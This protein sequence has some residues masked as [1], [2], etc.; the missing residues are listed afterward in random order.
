MTRAAFSAQAW[1]RSTRRIRGNVGAMVG[2]ALLLVVLGMAV[3]ADII[4]PY[5]STAQDLGHALQPP[6][7]AHWFGTDTVGRDIFSRV[8]AGSRISL[9]IV[10]LVLGVALTIGGALGSLAGYYGGL[11][12]EIVMR[13]ADVF[14]AFP[15][16]LLAMAVVAAL[17][18]G[19]QNAMIAIAV[20]YW[21]RYARLIRASI[22]KARAEPYIEAARSVGCLDRRII[23]RHLMPNSV[24]PVLVQATMDAGIAILTTAS[25]SFVGLGAVPPTPEWGAM[26]AGGRNYILTAWWI[27][28]FPG[29][30]ISIAVAGF[31]FLGDGLRDLLDPTLRG[32]VGF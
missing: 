15:H 9:Q 1:Y 30:L 8:V 17:G 4:A 10:I 5:P 29:I 14:F 23:V 11:V 13:V 3:F 6:S 22:L 31:M 24:A 28:T 2:I 27:P 32:R 25:L 20:A 21:P 7:L 19:L 18:P 12:D 26:V 16:F